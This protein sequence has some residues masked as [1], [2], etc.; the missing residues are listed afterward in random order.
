[1][2]CSCVVV[3]LTAGK[4]SIYLLIDRSEGYGANL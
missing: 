1:V 3:S 2:K 4:G